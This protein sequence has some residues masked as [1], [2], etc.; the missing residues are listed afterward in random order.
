MAKMLD[1]VVST[2]P[3]PA[4]ADAPVGGQDGYAWQQGPNAHERMER[5]RLELLELDIGSGSDTRLLNEWM[6][7][8]RVRATTEHVQKFHG[9]LDSSSAGRTASGSKRTSLRSQF[10]SLVSNVVEK[11]KMGTSLS[12]PIST[13]L[14][15]LSWICAGIYMCGALPSPAYA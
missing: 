10:A 9:E 14:T 2:A 1:A 7:L 5:R 15:V 4:D 13:I 8:L 6:M 3:A 12:G 11:A